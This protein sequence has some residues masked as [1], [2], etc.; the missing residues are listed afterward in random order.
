MF[1]RDGAFFMN[2]VHHPLQP[3]ENEFPER[4]RG[5]ERAVVAGIIIGD[6]DGVGACPD[7]VPGDPEGHAEDRIHQPVRKFG[8]EKEIREQVLEAVQEYR[9]HEGGAVPKEDGLLSL[10]SRHQL[11]E[12]S[13]AL[14]RIGIRGNV[15]LKI[16]DRPD[17]PLMG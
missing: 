17:G 6:D 10:E 15:F 7:G 2:G 5:K 4:G 12:F 16:L 1:Y 11:G 14:R 8:L 13:Q 3:R 9:P